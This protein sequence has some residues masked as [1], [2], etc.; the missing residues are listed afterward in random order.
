L[1]RESKGRARAVSPT[2]IKVPEF[3]VLDDSLIVFSSSHSSGWSLNFDKTSKKPI[4]VNLAFM[5]F[6]L[7]SSMGSLGYIEFEPQRYMF[8][9]Y[10]VSF[11]TLCILLFLWF[12]ESRRPT[13]PF[14]KK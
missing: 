3:D 5:G 13:I 14:F 8:L 6:Q 4:I 2:K 10:I 1:V 7:D 12:F 9:G 11:I